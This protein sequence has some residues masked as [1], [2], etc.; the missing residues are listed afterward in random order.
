MDGSKERQFF[1]WGL[2]LRSTTQ[3]PD[4][5]QECM[6]F[7]SG[8]FILEEKQSN[9]V[10][11][12]WSAQ[13]R[14]FVAITERSVLLEELTT[15]TIRS[16]LQQDKQVH[17]V[18]EK[19]TGRLEIME[20]DC[21]Y[22]R[23]EEAK[24]ISDDT[25]DDDP[26]IN[27]NRAEASSGSHTPPH[28]IVTNGNIQEISINENI[29]IMSAKN[30]ARLDESKY[31]GEFIPHFIKYKELEKNNTFSCANDDVMDIRGESGEAKLPEDWH[32]T[33]EDYYKE[34]TK[35]G[36][37]KSITDW[38]RVTEELN[39]L[40]EED[41]KELVKLKKYLNRVMLPLVES[42]TKPIP[43]INASDTSEHHYWS[44]F[45]HRFFSKALQDFVGLDWRAMEVP[46][47]ASK[48]RKNY[49]HNHA[50]DKIVDGKYADLLARMWTNN[51]E[52]FIGE[53][54]GS[55]SQPDLTKLATDSFKLY[56]E[57]RDCLN[58]RILKAMG[59]ED[60]NYNNRKDG[61][62]VYEEF[63]SLHIASNLDQIPMMKT[64]ML[65]LLEFMMIIKTE[66]ENTM[67]T[68]YKGDTIQIL[69]RKFNDLISTKSS[70]TK[71]PKVKK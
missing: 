40:K 31:L 54:A 23:Q 51:E 8:G 11:K 22:K 17:L 32:N 13:Q 46:V 1:G 25:E 59:K 41:N 50:T 42:F 39:V 56:R 10:T 69:K 27:N 49:G 65:K 58:V 55:P 57:M 2:V 70:P 62:Y 34:T 67:T 26:F 60:I 21:S 16:T 6:S 68:K 18:R 12:F 61:V 53:Q 48:Y 28:Q 9:L 37:K 29:L 5:V 66:V 38:I 30:L 64:D 7:V 71:V 63:G 3:H 15:S 24:T 20:D 33:V 36:S 14:K 45:G 19:V 43:D 44:E 35:S 4:F 47:M 52:I